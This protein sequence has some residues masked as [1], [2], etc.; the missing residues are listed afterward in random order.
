MF[1]FS[2]HL[3]KEFA[4][5]KKIFDFV[6]EG[7]SRLAKNRK[8]LEELYSP[9][10]LAVELSTVSINLGRQAGHTLASSMLYGHYT[11]LGYKVFVISHNKSCA[12]SIRDMERTTG[13]YVPKNRCFSIRTALNPETWRGIT[14]DKTIFIVDNSMKQLSE[15]V[16]SIANM[17]SF[18]Y[19]QEKPFFIGLGR[20]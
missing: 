11:K 7:L 5:E 12:M 8:D 15:T 6:T 14:F 17:E 13:V 9:V 19:A 16:E 10:N 4:E 1:K 18:K 3:V 20:N 2:F